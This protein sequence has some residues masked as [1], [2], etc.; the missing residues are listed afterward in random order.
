MNLYTDIDKSPGY[1]MIHS[2]HNIY[3]TYVYL[4]LRCAHIYIPFSC[5]RFS[6]I[7]TI[8]LEIWSSFVF[9]KFVCVFECVRVMPP[10]RV[11]QHIYSQ[12]CQES[13]RALTH[14]ISP[15]R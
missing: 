11:M 9:Y 4:Y 14:P 15:H 13:A 3:N 2:V 10:G 5:F 8:E 7:T 6:P 12:R 1:V